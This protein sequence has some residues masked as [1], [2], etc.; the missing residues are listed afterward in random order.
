MKLLDVRKSSGTESTFYCF[1]PPVMIITFLIE[2]G[3]AVYVV[4]RYKLTAISRLA[5]LLLVF[6]A[7]FQ[8]AE[9]MVCTGSITSAEWWARLGY[10]AIT[11]LPPL[12]VH[13]AYR[14]ARTTKQFFVW[15]SYLAMIGFAA[16][17]AF[18]EGA[19]RGQACLGNYVMFELPK[20]ASG[21]YVAY[22]YGLLALAVVLALHF[23]RHT[24]QR[25]TK[26]ALTALIVGYSSF[27]LPTAAVNLF[28]AETIRGIPS[29]MCGF[30]VILA[31]VLVGW[32]LPNVLSAKKNK[33]H[34]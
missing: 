30:A 15:P 26:L 31:I 10:V 11:I 25:R 17:F 7:T 2:I 12:G 20:V 28:N 14:I 5:L 4:W 6:L 34:G 8:L 22:Y 32:I 19:I 33:R 24:K 1:S 23:I 29:I 27:I 21:L 13:L 16:Y 3:L 9:Y 18:A